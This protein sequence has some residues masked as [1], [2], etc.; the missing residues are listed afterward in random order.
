M[1]I[2]IGDGRIT[3]STTM[4]HT[5]DYAFAPSGLHIGPE[6][7]AASSF[8]DAAGVG[9]EDIFTSLLGANTNRSLDE[10]ERNPGS[11]NR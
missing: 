3:K 7:S 10:A 8:S 6:A 2:R 1:L 9:F 5:P 4:A 11:I